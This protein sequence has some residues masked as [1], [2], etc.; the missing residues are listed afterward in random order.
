M[1]EL[2]VATVESNKK[3]PSEAIQEIGKKLKGKKQGLTI[4]FISSFYDLDKISKAIKE[5]L[6]GSIIGCTTSGELSALGYPEHSISA[7][8]LNSPRLLTKTYFIKDLNKFDNKEARKIKSSITNDLEE[9]KKI[10]PESKP[11]ALLLVDGLSIKEEILSS[12][13]RSVIPEVP[14]FGG[15][16]GDDLKF[17]KTFVFHKGKFHENAAVFQTFITDHAFEIFKTQH[18]TPLEDSKLV[19]TEADVSKRIVYEINGLPASEEYA[20]LINVEESKLNPTIFSKHP[21]MIKVGHE[22]YVRSIQKVNP[23]KSLTFYC[24]IDVGLVLTVANGEDIIESLDNYLL[25]VKGRINPKVILACECILRRLEIID[26]NLVIKASDVMERHGVIGF[27]TYGEQ[28]N[29]LHVNQT[30]TALALGE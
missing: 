17:E 11:F 6:K 21:I 25:S 16:A 23:D 10:R 13:L 4:L 1:S 8:F 26:K 29:G 3:D 5:N 30:L 22:Y 9:H 24:A 2:T 28:I 7:L 14:F 12:T 19:I 18:F 27:H 15:S 20:R